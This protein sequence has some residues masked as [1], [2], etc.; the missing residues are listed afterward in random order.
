[1]VATNRLLNPIDRRW[2]KALPQN[3]WWR[4]LANGWQTW[5]PGSLRSGEKSRHIEHLIADAREVSK[6]D[7][8]AAVEILRGIIEQYASQSDYE[9]YVKMAQ[10]EL[11]RLQL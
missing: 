2:L 5:K 9:S 8:P 6:S 11:S 1:M 4:N 10:L 7:L 3:S